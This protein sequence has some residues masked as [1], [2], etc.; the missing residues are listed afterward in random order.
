[1]NTKPNL[2][3][4]YKIEELICFIENNDFNNFKKLVEWDR[5]ILKKTKM[6]EMEPIFYAIKYKNRKIFDFILQNSKEVQYDVKN[7][8]I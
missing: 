8:F 2:K 7:K 6:D 4:K 1:M 5:K 3:V